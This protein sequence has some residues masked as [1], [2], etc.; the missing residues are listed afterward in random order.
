[1]IAL[2]TNV[3][4]TNLGMR[5]N[6]VGC[7]LSGIC[8]ALTYQHSILE[9]IR[10][11]PQEKREE[12]ET[13]QSRSQGHSSSSFIVPR[14]RVTPNKHN[15]KKKQKKSRSFQYQDDVVSCHHLHGSCRNGE[16]RMGLVGSKAHARVCWGHLFYYLL[17]H[18]QP[19][20]FH[21]DLFPTQTEGIQPSQ[22]WPSCL[23]KLTNNKQNATQTTPPTCGN[24]P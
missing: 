5:G 14:R 7:L 17:H 19:R 6:V 15:K 4:Q 12:K 11:L 22:A 2:N 18:P 10:K 3:N 23:A 13:R 9:L 20:S 16:T 8:G 1:M 21:D 24:D